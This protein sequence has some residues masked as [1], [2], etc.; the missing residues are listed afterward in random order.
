MFGDPVPDHL[1]YRPGLRKHRNSSPRSSSQQ[2]KALPALCWVDW[3][4]KAC[5]TRVGSLPTHGEQ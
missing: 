5:P 2:E 3:P 1:P 4:A